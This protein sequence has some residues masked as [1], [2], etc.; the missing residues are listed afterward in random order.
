MA[1]M[2]ALFVEYSNP[3]H[4]LNANNRFNR[5]FYQIRQTFHNCYYST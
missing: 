5:V 3:I 1:K 4:E 2:L